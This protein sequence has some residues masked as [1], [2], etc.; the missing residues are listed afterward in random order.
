LILR[1]IM[2]PAGSLSDKTD[3]LLSVL[4]RSLFYF[5]YPK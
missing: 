3:L 4:Q 2:C 1:I 5:Q